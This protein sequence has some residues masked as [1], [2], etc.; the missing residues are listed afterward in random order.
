LV[1]ISLPVSWPGFASWRLPSYSFPLFLVFPLDT[2]ILLDQT[3]SQECTLSP[4]TYVN[5]TKLPLIVC[6][7]IV[8]MS[9][10]PA[11]EE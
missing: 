7:E 11:D 3:H 8:R 2:E 5:Q 1:T 9:D 6:R 10:T 4:S